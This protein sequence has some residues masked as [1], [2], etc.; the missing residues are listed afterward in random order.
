[1]KVSKSKFYN[2]QEYLE[3][4]HAQMDFLSS[5]VLMSIGQNE[6]DLNKHIRQ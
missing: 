3:H 2:G 4:D 1:M 5:N 6:T